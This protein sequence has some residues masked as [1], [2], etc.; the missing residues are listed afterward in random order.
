MIKINLIPPE[1][2]ARINR[3]VLIAKVVLAVVVVAVSI[4]MAS[5]WHIGRAKAIEVKLSG[6]EQEMRVLQKDVDRAKEIEKQI[7]EV[8]KYLNSINSI[9]KGRFIYTNF[10]QDIISDLPST[11]WFTSMN[12][13]LSGSVV[14]VSL[15]VSANSAYDLSYWI[16]SL[17]ISGPYSEVSIGAI[18]VTTTD[19]G[20][21]FT[22]P[23]T[24]KYTVK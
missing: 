10:L 12:T 23:L 18:S 15:G 11:L 22:V 4:L 16:N 2:I 13:T 14:S 7:A 19:L 8:Q 21:Q 24:V 20:K 5:L 6:L 3:N 9:N 17:E 1:Y